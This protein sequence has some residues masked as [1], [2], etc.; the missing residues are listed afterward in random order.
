VVDGALCSSVYVP[1]NLHSDDAA[2]K[3]L[4]ESVQMH[5]PL[6]VIRFPLFSRIMEGMV[7]AVCPYTH[8]V[9]M[10]WNTK[11]ILQ[12]Q[13]IELLLKFM[14]AT[15]SDS[16]RANT[17]ILL[18]SRVGSDNYHVSDSTLIIVDLLRLL[19]L[20]PYLF[21]DRFGSK[22]SGGQKSLS[23]TLRTRCRLSWVV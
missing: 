13:N 3:C 2:A 21:Y 16:V 6:P 5:K 17:Q 4:F 23:P 9:R 7:V 18:A 14:G 1:Y 10:N 11:V 20:S 19:C 22:I 12:K 8:E 15:I